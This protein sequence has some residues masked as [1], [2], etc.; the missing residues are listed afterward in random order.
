MPEGHDISPP[1]RATVLGLD[2][3]TRRVGVAVGDVET[4]IATALDTIRADSNAAKLDGVAAHVAEW[5]PAL[6]VLGEPTHA[7]GGRHETA[8]L[9]HKFA[10]RLRERFKLPVEW[11]DETLSSH[12]AQILLR[13]RGFD[14]RAARDKLDAVAAQIILQSWLDRR[15]EAHAA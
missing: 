6:L 7:D 9:A 2:F 13:E 11:C 5:Q 14:A 12:E 4:G 1:G 8:R 10:N 3:G 15:R